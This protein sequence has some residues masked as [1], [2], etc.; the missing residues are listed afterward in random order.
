LTDH[1]GIDWDPA[2]SADGERLA[3]AS[4]RLDGFEVWTAFA[5]GSGVQRLTDAPF[6]VADPVLSP[7]GTWIVFADTGE[8][9]LW[10]VPFDLAP[11]APPRRL[12]N[13]PAAIPRFSPD[14]SRLAYLGSSEAGPA[15][16]VVAW[17]VTGVPPLS[18]I[19]VGRA[20]RTDLFLPGR[21]DWYAVTGAQAELA[22]L[23]HGPDS[24]P[25]LVAQGQGGEAARRILLDSIG[26]R[27]PETFDLA[28]DG[29]FLV[30]SRLDLHQ[31][32]V[33]ALNLPR[34]DS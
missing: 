3:W 17:P 14:G 18:S 29:R 16:V 15:L 25:V 22:W 32:L 7:D 6:D 2:V 9:G 34:S 23:D 19:Q 11:P 30:V 33:I 5:D 1:P 4:D 10:A 21:A 27:V 8:T 26:G 20:S 13:G 12:V 24:R 31:H 28:A